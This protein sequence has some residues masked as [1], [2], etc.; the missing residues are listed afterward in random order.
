MSGNVQHVMERRAAALAD[1]INHRV[2]LLTEFL[3]PDGDRPVFTKKL[4]EAEA[5][6]FWQKHRYDEIGA[7]ILA[8]WTPEQIMSLDVALSRAASEGR[9]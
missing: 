1:A 6:S 8:G 2:E 7:Q 3:R 5:L 9:I 4:S